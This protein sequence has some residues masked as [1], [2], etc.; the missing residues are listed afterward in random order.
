MFIKGKFNSTLKH[1]KIAN[2]MKDQVVPNS[3]L[4]GKLQIDVFKPVP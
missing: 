3:R 4:L 2:F 1:K